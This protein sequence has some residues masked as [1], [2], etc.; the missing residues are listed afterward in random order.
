MFFSQWHRNS[1]E[2]KSVCLVASRALVDFKRRAYPFKGTLV[3]YYCV[4]GVMTLRL[5]GRKK[6]MVRLF[7]EDGQALACTVIHIE[8]N[9]V[10]Q[11]KLASKDGYDAI[12]LGCE[13]VPEQKKGRLSKAMQ[14]KFS[15]AGISFFRYLHECRVS[16]DFQL[17]QE[18]KVDSFSTEDFVDVSGWSKGKGYQGVMVRHGFS[19]GPAAH[20][21]GFHRHAGSCGV[22]RS[23]PGR[24]F[25]G[26]K[27]A[28]R[29]GGERVVVECLR[30][31]RV[32]VEQSL[33]LVGGAIPG[34]REG[35]VF[36]RKSIKY[37]S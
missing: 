29:M 22:G 6:G 4:R 27:M 24:T 21:S 31:L 3:A 16:G 34:S 20:G 15:K 35:R 28:G 7:L 5:M 26:T 32:D 14:G 33:M 36:V 10:A 11:V 25:L 18:I 37:S 1:V 17:G 2:K 8:P 23:T 12:Q 13:V 9:V 19:G 30:V